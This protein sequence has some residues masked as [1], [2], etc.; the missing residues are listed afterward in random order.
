VPA[1]ALTRTGASLPPAAG[2]GGERFRRRVEHAIDWLF[3]GTVA[4]SVYGAMRVGIAAI[5]LVRHADWLRPWVYLE[6]HRFVR[7]LMFMDTSALAP[8]LRS[9]L[10]PFL[11]LGDT[12]THVL[13]YARTGLSLLLLIGVRARVSAALLALVSYLLFAADR[14][15]YYHHLHLLYVTL[16]WLALAP[17]GDSMTLTR[18]LSRLKARFWP[19]SEE[20]V[21]ASRRRAMSPL[22]PLQ[23]LR[24]QALSVYVAAA[25]SKLDASFLRGDAL[26]E[27]ETAWVLKGA[28]WET[29]RDALGYGGVAMLSAGT[30]LV[31]ALG[32]AVRPTRRVS[33]LLAWTFHAGISLCMPVYSFGAQMAVLVFAF[34]PKTTSDP[35]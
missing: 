1:E 34:W 32:L 33:V 16:F 2:S 23:L 21:A 31:I 9:P 7:G 25:V 10:L 13:V 30:E 22:W 12:T 18:G 19:G 35:A 29:A 27:L 28:V 3:A 24:A 26:R 6:H 4:S 15:R 11:T 14:Y 17:I 5:F 20:P 8:R